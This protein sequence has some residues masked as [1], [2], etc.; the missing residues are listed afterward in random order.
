MLLLVNITTWFN[1]N[2]YVYHKLLFIW[3]FIIIKMVRTYIKKT[4]RGQVPENV[5]KQAADEVISKENSLRKAAEK[6][7]I[8]FMTLQRYIK[9]KIK[10][11]HG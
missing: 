5:Y 11:R 7:D 3:L 1:Q 10:T 8:N 2:K 4:D 6:Y 9:K